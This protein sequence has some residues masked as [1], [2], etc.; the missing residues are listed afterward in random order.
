MKGQQ[1]QDATALATM[2]V[3]GERRLLASNV[4]NFHRLGRQHRI[5]RSSAD[6]GAG[7]RTEN[8]RYGQTQSNRKLAALV[9]RRAVPLGDGDSRQRLFCCSC[10]YAADGK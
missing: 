7:F 1:I 6:M 4:A 3:R 2:L 5:D 9:L 10:V 8:V